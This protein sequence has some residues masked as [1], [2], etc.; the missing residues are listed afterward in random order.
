MFKLTTTVTAV[1]K[2]IYPGSQ[3]SILVWDS[4]I[5][6]AIIVLLKQSPFWYVA[7]EGEAWAERREQRS[8]YDSAK[9]SPVGV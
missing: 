2:C 3:W 5:E 8:S 4:Q 1:H 7:G 6:Q 9:L